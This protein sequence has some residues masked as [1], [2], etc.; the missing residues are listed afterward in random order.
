MP[1]ASPGVSATALCFEPGARTDP[2]ATISPLLH[3]QFYNGQLG[4]RITRPLLMPM[5]AVKLRVLLVGHLSV[6][7]VSWGPFIPK[8]S[9]SC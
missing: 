4:A 5:R 2:I 8:L 9:G 3:R 6:R 1:I 7:C